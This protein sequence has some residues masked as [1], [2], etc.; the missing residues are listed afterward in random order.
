M[1]CHANTQT[2]AFTIHQQKAL[3]AL[4][5]CRTAALGGHI[6]ACDECGNIS[7]SYNSCRN[8]HCP[9]CQSTQR[10]KWI[11]GRQ[12]KLLPVRYFHVVFTL[13]QQ[14][15]TYCLHYPTVLYNLLFACSEEQQVPHR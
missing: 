14:L 1:L 10:E 4:Q 13:P 12:Q 8:R 11:E 5:Q 2:E 6:D 3:R 9:K 7:I 15:N